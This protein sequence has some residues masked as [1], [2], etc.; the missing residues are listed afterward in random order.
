MYENGYA[1]IAVIIL[2]KNYIG[3]RNVSFVSQTVPIHMYSRLRLIR[4]VLRASKFSV[5]K[6]IEIVILWVNHT[7][8][9]GFSSLRHF[10]HHY[11][12]F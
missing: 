11:S 5:L 6:L 12:T 2:V 7:I 4:S 8:P 1:L 9:F 10:W 3:I